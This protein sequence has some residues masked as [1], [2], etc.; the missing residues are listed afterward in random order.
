M[1][2]PLQRPVV[3]FAGG[4]TGGH[5]YP[6]LA[7]ARALD[8]H[9]PVFLI[10]PDRGDAERVNGEFRVAVLRAPRPD[11]S[12]LL[13]PVRLAAAV[14][15]ARGILTGLR[16]SAVVGLG[17]YASVPAALAGRSLG[18]PL[19]LMQCD[20]VMGRATRLLARFAQ[21]VGLGSERARDGLPHRIACRV[22][23]TPLRR[24]MHARGSRRDFGLDP[25]LPTLLVTGGSQGAEGLN[26]RVIE[27]LAACTGRDFQVLHCA[28]ARD[29][30]RVRAAY[31]GLGV[32]GNVVDFLPEIGRAYGISDL[33]LARA[34][35]STVAECA[36]LGLPA[37]FVPYPF[38]RDRQQTWNALDSVRAGAARIVEESDLDP[39]AFR[40]IVDGILL[41]EAE[42]RSMSEGA[43][44]V[45]RPDAARDMAAHLMETFG[46]A[47]SEPR[48]HAELGG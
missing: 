10:P 17:G 25:S 20:A 32:R 46:A 35:A 41:D 38:H 19:Y 28:G 7:V 29:A 44:R 4:G 26:T 15:R 45:A 14:A 37:V 18:L 27:G 31:A 47:L 13:Y 12:R 34:G 36:A 33:V 16:A 42:R 23:G 22:T 8:G 3:V 40:A 43:A 21:G 11:R 39:A 1:I 30:A 6:G 2:A 48:W 5:L 9:D 24:E